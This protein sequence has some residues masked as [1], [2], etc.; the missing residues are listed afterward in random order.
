MCLNRPEHEFLNPYWQ[1]VDDN[2]RSKN[3]PISSIVRAKWYQNDVYSFIERFWVLQT[4]FFPLVGVF[5]LSGALAVRQSAVTCLAAS[6]AAVPIWMWKHKVNDL[7]LVQLGSSKIKLFG[8]N[9]TKTGPL[10]LLKSNT[11]LIVNIFIFKFT[12]LALE[13]QR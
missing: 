11:V 12:K 6:L 7:V 8:E 2:C 1:K 13:M 4:G 5:E 3:S 9:T 10:I